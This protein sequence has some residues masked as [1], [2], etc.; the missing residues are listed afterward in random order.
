MKFCGVT[1]ETSAGEGSDV[2]SKLISDVDNVMLE[3]NTIAAKR[4]SQFEL[5][6]K[7]VALFL[8]RL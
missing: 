8:R 4:L 5:I 3:K 6:H 1:P 7:Q 2:R